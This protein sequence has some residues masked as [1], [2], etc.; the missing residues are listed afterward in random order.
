MSECNQGFTLTQ[1]VSWGFLCCTPPTLG[2]VSQPHYVE[3]SS[4]GVVSSKEASN[5]R[6][7]HPVEGQWPSLNS[8][9]RAWDQ[10]SSLSVS[11]GK[12]L[13]HCH[14]LV[15]HPAFYIFSYILPRDVQA[16]FWSGKLVNSSSAW[17]LISSFISMH[18][19]VSGDLKQSDRMLG[20]NVQCLLALLYQWG[21][22]FGSLKAFQSCL[23]VRANTDIFLWSSWVS[24]VRVLVEKPEGKRPL[25]RF[26]C[27]WE[28]NMKMD[29]KEIG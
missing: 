15:V 10:V 2:T 6:G 1:N 24:L 17:E 20:G 23:T 11:T 9:T 18:L 19:R 7:L 28:D 13:P 22:C 29:I 8:R 12:T 25:E 27:R 4:Q 26:R 14:V 5:N 16:R 21:C 3:M